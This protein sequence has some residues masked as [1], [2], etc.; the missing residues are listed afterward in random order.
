[1]P[2]LIARW[3]IVEKYLGKGND[4]DFRVPIVEV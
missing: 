3:Y 4:T 2:R 1:L